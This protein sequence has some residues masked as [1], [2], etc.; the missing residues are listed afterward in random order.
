MIKGFW[1]GVLQGLCAGTMRVQWS[2]YF[3]DGGV[4]GLLYGVVEGLVKVSLTVP[5]GDRIGG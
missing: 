2:F 1:S 3:G 5:F 4:F